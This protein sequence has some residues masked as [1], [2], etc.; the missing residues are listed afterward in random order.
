M[1]TSTNNFANVIPEAPLNVI[2]STAN[3]TSSITVAHT[4]NSGSTSSSQLK[5]RVGGS[6]GGD[7]YV[8]LEV[9]G[10]AEYAFGIDNSDSDKLILTNS[11]V[12]SAATELIKITTSGI[13]TIPIQPGFNSYVSVSQNNVTGD[14][15][16]Y[17][18]VCDSTT[19]NIGGYYNPGTG[20][21]TV[22]E[23]GFYLFICIL[24][25]EEM[26]S[27]GGQLC[28]VFL[29][30]NGTPTNILKFNPSLIAEGNG[31]GISNVSYLDFF[32]SGNTVGVGVNAG[33]GTKTITVVGNQ[34]YFQGSFLG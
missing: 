33:G 3:E 13:V 28:S 2:R 18:I 32:S 20:L 7:A 6:N 27:F 11:N 15:T 25:L 5:A 34:T 14:G 30:I 19:S 29:L 9:V 26:L 22:P 24:G 31:N 21:F 23:D 12:P 8:N 17:P 16:S 4:S 10:G 1:S